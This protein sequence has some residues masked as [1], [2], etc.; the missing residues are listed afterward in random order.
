MK[1]PEDMKKLIYKYLIFSLIFS[2]L[3]TTALFLV[4]QKQ[5]EIK[6]NIGHSLDHLYMSKI[7]DRQNKVGDES[8]R[9]ISAISMLF[10]PYLGNNVEYEITVGALAATSIDKQPELRIYVNKKEIISAEIFPRTTKINFSFDKGK[11]EGDFLLFY[12][13]NEG[14]RSQ[15]KKVIL[16][17]SIQITPVKKGFVTP[18]ARL[19]AFLLLIILMLSASAAIIKKECFFYSAPAAGLIVLTILFF[20]RIYFL[21]FIDILLTVTVL[22]LI[23]IA[24]VKLLTPVLLKKLNINPTLKTY[25]M[26][27]LV[28]FL[29]FFI[30]T[31]VWLYPGT[32]T[33]D[34]YFHAY[35]FQRVYSGGDILQESMT[36]EGTFHFPY[37]TL[38][39]I[40]LAPAKL[41]TGESFVNVLKVG[42]SLFD[43]LV[44]LLLF[45]F[46]AKSMRSPP[47]G[48][49]AGAIYSMVPVIR[50]KMLWGTCTE[51]F[52]I[53]TAWLF[54]TAMAYLYDK[55]HLKRKG[56]ILLSSLFL[57]PLFS[58][59]GT[60]LEIGMFLLV[61]L[62]GS[63]ITYESAKSGD[64]L[65][66][67][68][69]I[70]LITLILAFALYYVHFVEMMIDQ[71]K[72]VF[73]NRGQQVES[74]KFSKV[75][76]QW[77]RLV[78][79][80]GIPLLIL[81]VFSFAYYIERRKGTAGFFI[82]S[83][84]LLT[85]LLLVLAGMFSP[86]ELRWKLFAAPAVALVCGWGLVK[87][88]SLRYGRYLAIIIFLILLGSALLN[89]HAA[90]F[91][92][93][94]H[95]NF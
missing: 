38:L 36:P 34:I 40:L 47:A 42:V 85:S 13:I 21:P 59:F 60:A 80:Y 66:K 94:Y 90:M 19:I 68:A 2:I 31:A 9:R 4:Y 45:I 51:S 41:I 50:D 77:R 14:E 28:L 1:I 33:S 39:Y 18:S 95:L 10:L 63:Y 89:W 69:V 58:H 26:L 87:L 91:N 17:D 62:L 74:S 57:L 6:I 81:F 92:G 52:G 88:S 44:A 29:S 43:A 20:F 83:S 25:R 72:L 93:P 82:L 54:I 64:R 79:N 23:F 8:Y 75:A 32:M 76:A 37:P 22:S 7:Y 73:K 27:L 15:P 53:F 46:A 78:K 84:V 3:F 35:R 86:L 24:G 70:L 71:A 16:L 61:I 48:V 12:F 67:L 55:L 11:I 49:L 5:D 65:K 30:R 56:I